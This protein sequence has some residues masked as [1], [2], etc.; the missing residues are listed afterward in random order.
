L[1]LF[2]A[3]T[4]FLFLISEM[5]TTALYKF[6]ERCTVPHKT[7]GKPAVTE[8]HEQLYHISQYGRGIEEA[9]KFLY[10]QAPAF[11]TFMDWLKETQQPEE[12]DTV[13]DD[14]LTEAD[15]KF[16]D[17]NGYLV[18]KNAV[19]Q[20][21][22]TAA[23]TAIWD[24]LGADPNNPESWYKEHGGKNGLMLSFFHHPALNANR[25]SARIKKIYQELYG[26]TDIYLLIDKVSFNP[27]ETKYFSF[28]GS[29]LHWDVS[30]HTPIPYVLQGLL[31]L[32]DVSATDGAFHCVPG[33]HKKVDD[34]LAGLPAE[35]N[36]REIAMTE[37][38][39]VPVPGNAGDLVIWHQALPH[40]ATSNKGAVPRMV[41]YIAYKPVQMPAAEIW[42]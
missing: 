27:P 1:S 8:W 14:I 9:S 28:M 33:F 10:M 31:Y 35:A 34:W 2:K 21:Q 41:Q 15:M 3:G 23:Q 26:E 18:V 12:A 30:L 19:P 39:P 40:C 17:E 13:T 16:W 5:S 38:Q 7:N 37:L 36:A 24:F 29:P 22:C 32:N 6:W 11:E 42:K 4:I 25:R 20:E